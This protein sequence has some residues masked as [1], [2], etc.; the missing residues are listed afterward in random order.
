MARKT[1]SPEALQFYKKLLI[2]FSAISVAL[3]FL[4]KMTAVLIP[5]LAV[6]LVLPVVFLWHHKA[7]RICV[8]VAEI[9]VLVVFPVFFVGLACAGYFF[10]EY[11]ALLLTAQLVLP[12]A[13]VAASKDEKYDVIFVRI[14]AFVNTIFAVLVILFIIP[15]TAIVQIVLM[16]CTL[17]GTLLLT[18]MTHPWTLPSLKR[19]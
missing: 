5:I 18:F 7:A 2:V 8:R 16:G 13:A 3:S 9:L 10:T 15:K 12:A 11:F 17:L 1:D 4:Y 14:A 6:L 19:K